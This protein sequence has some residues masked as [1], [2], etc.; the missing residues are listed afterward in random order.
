[1]GVLAGA[2]NPTGQT[3]SL[4]KVFLHKLDFIIL[5]RSLPGARAL[6]LFSGGPVASSRQFFFWRDAQIFETLKR[7]KNR[8][9]MNKERLFF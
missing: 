2:K 5:S 4:K 6:M 8:Q 7:Q 1:L 3:I 9:M